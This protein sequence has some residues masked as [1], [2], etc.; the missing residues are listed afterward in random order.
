[1]NRILKFFFV[2]SVAIGC[3]LLFPSD[4]TLAADSPYEVNSTV[5]NNWDKTYGSKEY[6]MRTGKNIVYDIYSEKYTENGYSI[7]T[8][9]FGK[10]SQ[11][12]IRFQGWSVLFGHAR[13]TSTNHETY[14]VAEDINDFKNVKIYSTLHRG[15]LS[16]TEELEYNRAAST[17]S[18]VYNECAANAT[19]KSNLPSQDNGCNMRYDNVGFDAFLPIEELFPDISKAKT[20]R[21]YIVKK[22]NS[23]MVYTP[24]HIPFEFENKTYEGGDI[25]LSS[26]V[27]ARTLRMNSLNVLARTAPRGSNRYG[28]F[29]FDKDYTAKKQDE[30]GTSIWF[31]V[32]YGSN[33]AWTTSA[34][35]TF[36]GTQAELSFEPDDKP[37]VHVSDNLKG[38]YQDGDVTWVQPNET[39]TATLRQ[40]DPDSGN[41]YQFIRFKNSDVNVE[42]RHNFES[43]SATQKTNYFTNSELTINS[44]KRTENTSYGSVEWKVTPKVHG[45]SYNMLYYYQDRSGNTVGYKDTGRDLKVDGKTPTNTKS[46]ISGANFVDGSTYWVQPNKL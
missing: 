40:R 2:M 43:S 28:Y 26:G 29:T 5:K 3:Y 39:A 15:N 24:L 17:A 19:N 33:I 36:G 10:G 38:T 21:L 16:A 31:G 35:W 22:V 9:D 7:V 12:Y 34:Y 20:W 6:D 11:K 46:T 42:S 8:R 45:K 30:S 4:K 37:P 13:H 1:M 41:K 44:A 23:H 32:Q 25:S 27:E 14:I 18:T